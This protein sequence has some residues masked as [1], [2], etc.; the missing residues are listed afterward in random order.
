MNGLLQVA[1]ALYNLR[2]FDPAHALLDALR[3]VDPHRLEDVDIL[4]HIL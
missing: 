4:S 1:K 3:A 2:Q